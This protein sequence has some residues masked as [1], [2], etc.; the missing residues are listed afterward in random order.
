MIIS[1]PRFRQLT[2]TLSSK[3]KSIMMETVFIMSTMIW[4]NSFFIVWLF[5]IK[6]AGNLSSLSW[7]SLGVV[8]KKNRYEIIPVQAT[9]KRIKY[10]HVRIGYLVRR[11]YQ[12]PCG[13]KNH[14]LTVI[15][16]FSMSTFLKISKGWFGVCICFHT[17]ERHKGNSLV[18]EPPKNM[19]TYFYL[20][21]I[22]LGSVFSG[23]WWWISWILGFTWFNGILFAKVGQTLF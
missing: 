18:G 1:N 11:E 23:P 14:P 13:W 8:P 22:R 21:S 10:G 17:S 15:C 19:L 6:G 7:W 12:Q 9:R 3:E 16:T 2:L 20:T 4:L 5:L